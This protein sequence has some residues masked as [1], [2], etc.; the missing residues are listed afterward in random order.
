METRSASQPFEEIHDAL[1]RL[2]RSQLIPQTSRLEQSRLDITEKNRSSRLPWR[3]QFAP[4]LIE[5]F[6]DV[7]TRPGATVLDPFCG[8]GTVMFEGMAKD[9]HSIGADVNPAAYLLSSAVRF[10][11]IDKTKKAALMETARRLAH[12]FYGAPQGDFFDD[13]QADSGQIT[14]TRKIVQETEHDPDLHLIVALCLMLGMGDTRT[15]GLSVFE[16]GLRLVSALVNGLPNSKLCAKALLAD[17]RSLPLEDASVDLVIT[18]PP[19]INVFNYHQNYRPVLELMGWHPLMAAPTE[20]GANRK[21][22]QNRFLTV[23]QYCLDM[24]LAFANVS[25]VLRSNG[26]LVLVVG[27]SSSVLGT[28]FYNGDLLEAVLT[29]GIGFSIEEHRHRVFLNRFGERIYEEII[30]ANRPSD[31]RARSIEIGRSIG[32]SALE[33][34]VDKAPNASRPIILEALKQAKKVAPSPKL[35]ISIPNPSAHAETSN[36]VYTE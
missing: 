9:L 18:S 11:N 24:Q 33:A 3:G 26:R 5:Y 20:I 10:T 28:P 15:A 27:R 35:A 2:D 1:Q 14:A 23:V 13:Q 16:K 29:S 8:S 7:Y 32:L 30:V 19:Y 17:A 36:C 21:H 4:E 25:R 12:K 22:R 31:H 6:L 34:A